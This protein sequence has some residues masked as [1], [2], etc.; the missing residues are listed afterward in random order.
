MQRSVGEDVVQTAG[1]EHVPYQWSGTDD[2][3]LGA[4]ALGGHVEQQPDLV[5][6]GRVHELEAAEIDD[7]ARRSMTVERLGDRSD[8]TSPRE[9]V[10]LP[11]DGHNHRLV[12][13]RA[14]G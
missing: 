10:E 1:R 3:D 11:G 8:E 14:A 9:Q 6:T 2:R 5:Q 13:H 4:P 7:D 12:L